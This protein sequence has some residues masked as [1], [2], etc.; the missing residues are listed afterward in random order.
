MSEKPYRCKGS[1]KQG[2]AC[3]NQDL[4]EGVTSCQKCTN[5][6]Y[7]PQIR[8][9]AIATEAERTKD[10]PADRVKKAQSIKI[11]S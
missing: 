5:A 1:F 6:N 10:L 11:E 3:A 2:T 9:V 8:T 4:P 7:T